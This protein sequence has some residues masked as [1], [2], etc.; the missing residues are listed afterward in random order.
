MSDTSNL[1]TK[2][3]FTG[4]HMLAL[5]LCFFGVIIAVNLTM[6]TLASKSWTGLIVKNSYVAS[7]KFNGELQNA[8]EQ[9]SRG[10]NSSV[11]YA[12]GTLALTLRD[13]SGEVLKFDFAKAEIGR[14]AYEQDDQQFQFMP[15]ASGSNKIAVQLDEGIWAINITGKIGDKDYRRD[16]RMNVDAG[17]KGKI[18]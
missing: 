4:K 11:S 14:P 13:K 10:W 15:L 16:I 18:L 8:A 3:E 17:G 9:N 6:A 12:M 7:Q 2:F 1:K 5:M